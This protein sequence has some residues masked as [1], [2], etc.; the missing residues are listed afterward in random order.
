MLAYLIFE[1]LFK[2]ASETVD[3]STKVGRIFPHKVVFQTVDI[4]DSDLE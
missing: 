1:N 3:G 4:S 2:F